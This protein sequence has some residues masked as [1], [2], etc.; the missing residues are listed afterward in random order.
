LYFTKTGQLLQKDS[1]VR[2][3]IKERDDFISLGKWAN[4]GSLIECEC[5]AWVCLLSDQSSPGPREHGTG[6]P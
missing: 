4:N 1:N 5:G 6:L 2:T 3:Q